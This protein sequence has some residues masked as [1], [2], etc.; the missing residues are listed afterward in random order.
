MAWNPT[1]GAYKAGSA[2]ARALP[3]PVLDPIVRGLARGVA[4]ISP[5]RRLVVERNLRRV[6]GHDLPPHDLAR[7]VNE[8]FESYG[9]YWAES[10]RLPGLSVAEIDGPFTQEGYEHI[11]AAGVPAPEKLVT[12]AHGIG[13][14]PVE[15]PVGFP[16]YGLKGAQGFVVEENMTVSLDCLYFGGKYGPCHME[17]I[18][19]TG[20]GDPEPTYAS[21]LEI[22]GP[23]N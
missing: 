9:R 23:R 15:M 2:V 1:L 8:T 12:F 4:R 16:S 14:T 19:I 17:N 6:H 22:R 21:P 3:R 7:G 5:E 11:K 18:Y 10:F 13:L 20:S